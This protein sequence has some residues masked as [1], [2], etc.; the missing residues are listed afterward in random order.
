MT[1]P[2]H[3]I[4]HTYAEYLALEASSNIK[5]E[6]LGGQIYAMA[7]GTPEHAALAAAVIGLLF[8]QL[9]D[10]GCRAYDADLRVRTRSGLA[11]YPDV[12]VICGA[13]ERDE[14]DP[15]AVTNPALIIEVLSRSTEE[16]DAGDKFDHYKTL[17]SLQQYVLVSHRERS[18]EVW[19]L[20]ADG[21]WRSIH[22]EGDTVE[23]A[24]GARLDVR[25]LYESA[26]EPAA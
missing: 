10:R 3:E 14:T 6:F 2:L 4:H 15:Q 22:H 17:P 24:I 16:Y 26:G 8:P 7:G 9:R 11:T 18:L 1:A 23:L 5:H 20:G 19:A 13:T 21:W 12:T 25:E